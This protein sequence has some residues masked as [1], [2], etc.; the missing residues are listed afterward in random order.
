VFALRQLDGRSTAEVADL[1]G[2]GEGTVKRHLFRAVHTLRD[3]LKEL[4]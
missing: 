4:S 2:L 1:L 3:A